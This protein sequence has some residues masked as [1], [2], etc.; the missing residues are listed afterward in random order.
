MFHE[1]NDYIHNCQSY[2]EIDR[3]DRLDI[4]SDSYL[5]NIDL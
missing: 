5:C 1:L 4:I 3:E 2:T